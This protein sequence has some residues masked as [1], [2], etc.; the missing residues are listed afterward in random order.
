[1]ANHYAPPQSNVDDVA[2]SGQGVSGEMINALRGTKGWVRLMGILLLIGAAFMV[3]AGISIMFAGA[4]VGAVSRMPGGGAM[5]AGMGLTYIVLAI[6]YIFP[7]WL[8]IKYASAIGRLIGSGQAGDMEDALHMQRKF[9]KFTGILSV[10]FLVI[11]VIG[12]IAAIALPL[13]MAT[14]GG[15]H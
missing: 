14:K 5:M 15:L 13:F 11:M 7:G 6:I 10:I 1:M 4:S 12:I 2:P 8:L 3:L 9:W